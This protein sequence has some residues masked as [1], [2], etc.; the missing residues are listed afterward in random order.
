M[1][2]GRG[3]IFVILQ[4]FDF[5][6]FINLSIGCVSFTTS[7]DEHLSSSTFMDCSTFESECIVDVG[8]FVLLRFDVFLN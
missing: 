8:M 6:D 7:I 3:Q 4:S 5:I 2:N 1:R